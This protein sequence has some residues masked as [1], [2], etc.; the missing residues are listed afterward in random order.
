MKKILLLLLIVCMLP[1]STLAQETTNKE[2]LFPDALYPAQGANGK[3]G[4][5][6]YSG[7]WVIM[8]QWDYAEEFRGQYAVVGMDIAG[9]DDSLEG[10]IDKTGVYLMPLASSYLFDSGYDGGYY[11]GKDTGIYY[12]LY[13]ES[14][15]PA[16]KYGF[17]DIPSGY[18]SG[19]QWDSVWNWVDD[20]GLIDVRNDPDYLWGCVDRTTGNMVFPYMDGATDPHPFSE[21]WR[22]IEHYNDEDDFI[23]AEYVDMQG[24][25]LQLPN[26]IVPFEFDSFSR[27]L[28]AVCDQETNLLGFIDTAG[29]LVIK[30]AYEWTYGFVNG[31]AAVELTDGGWTLIDKAGKM[32]GG[33]WDR[34][35]ELSFGFVCVK[36]NDKYGFINEAGEIVIEPVWDYADY[37]RSNGL[38]WVEDKEKDCSYLMDV[39]GNLLSDPVDIPGEGNYYDFSEGLAA[40]SRDGLFGFMNEKGDIVIPCTWSYAGDFVNGLA[41]VRNDDKTGYIDHNGEFVFSWMESE[42][43]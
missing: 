3:M 25:K 1:I 27:G 33:I 42:G 26:G 31:Y 41:Y 8:P 16:E 10:L 40:V 22:L 4:Y 20:S 24:H 7:E 23:G 18:V 32:I 14:N 35:D 12:V 19:P 6:N 21:G 5:I 13:P 17:V 29:N 11:G 30:P 34:V 37:F 43:P 36:K 38:C 39:K 9:T 2:N 28:A 15:G